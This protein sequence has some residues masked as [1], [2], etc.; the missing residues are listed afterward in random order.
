MAVRLYDSLDP[1]SRIHSGVVPPAN[2]DDLSHTELKNLAVALF[3]QVVE[4]RRTT[5][6]PHAAPNLAGDRRH[7]FRRLR[8]TRSPRHGSAASTGSRHERDRNSMSERVFRMS[9]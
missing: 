3:E 1:T 2:L 9:S 6:P 7:R 8:G 4:L 5:R